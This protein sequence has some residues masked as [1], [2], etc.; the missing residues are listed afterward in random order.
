MPIELAEKIGFIG[1]LFLNP[2]IV[3]AI[4]ATFLAGVSWMLVVSKFDLSYAYPWTSLNFVLVL[5]LG[6]FVFSEPFTTTKFIG[7]LLV[8]IGIV[9]ISKG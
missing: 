3:S 6:F 4:I 8:I 2:W 9:V 5:A 1:K 7:T